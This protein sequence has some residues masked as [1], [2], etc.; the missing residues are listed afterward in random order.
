MRQSYTREEKLKVCNDAMKMEENLY[1]P[2]EKY[3]FN[4][5]RWIKDEVKISD[6]HKGRKHVQFDRTS[7]YPNV[8]ETL[9]NE[10][11]KLRRKGVKVK[12]W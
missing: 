4:T 12:G 11:R 6:S 3:D 8:E 10:Y 1:L 5:M 7:H 2:C 9:H